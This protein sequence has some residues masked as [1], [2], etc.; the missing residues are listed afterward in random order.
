[1]H[2]TVRGPH[3]RRDFLRL[4]LVGLGA[5]SA[6]SLLAACG[7]AAAPPS[8]APTTAPAAAAPTAAAAAAAKPTTAPAAAATTAP[9]AAATTAPAAGAA[10]TPTVDAATIAGPTATPYPVANFGSSSAKVKIRYWTIL[11]SVDGIVMN[12]LVRKFADANPD[13]GVESLQGVIDFPTKM[14]A[15]AI[16][17]TAPDVC[18][19]RHTYIGPFASKGVLSE[20]T[21]S[22]LDQVGIAQADFDPT[23]WKF[24]QYQGKQYTVPLDIHSHA[25]MY[26]K[27]ILA[28]NNLKVPTTLDEWMN[29]VSTVTQGDIL[30]YNTFAIGSGAQEFLTWGWYTIAR[31][32]GA[33]MVTPDGTKAAFNSPEGIAAVQW[34]H[35]IQQKGNPK[36][37]PSGDLQRTGNVASWP[38]GPWIVT[39]YFDKTKSSAADDLDVA[40]MPQHDLSKPAVWAQSH[41]FALPKQRNADPAKRDATLRFVK[42]M[43]EHSVDWAKAGQVPARNSARQEALTADD[44]Y[45]KKL[46]T[47][48]SQLPYATFMPSFPQILEVM[49]RIAS[50][51]EGA[52]LGQWSVQEGLSKAESE[53]NAILAA[54]A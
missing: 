51:V 32:F 42:W 1:M 36:A 30:G 31:Q 52:L 37:V 22:E 9:A 41:Q 29:V 23:V 14:E 45:L 35:D 19:V 11:G 21:Q 6:A 25:M 40:V 15:A 54:P 17:G 53:V 18:I 49:P 24:T 33:Q 34:M 28:K 12:E 10:A 16:S 7:P 47:W 2:E 26:D 38:D 46:Q 39:L 13:I 27:A 50:N 5:T 43:G 20:L 8:A 44:P 3:S 48:A 4:T